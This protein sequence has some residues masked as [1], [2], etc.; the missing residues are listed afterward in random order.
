M[1]SVIPDIPDHV[2]AAM[3]A[4]ER[5]KL[6]RERR[7]LVV[8]ITVMQTRLE[9]LDQRLHEVAQGERVLSNH[10]RRGTGRY[11]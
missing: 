5:T 10:G 8:D 1:T 6:E 7:E 11:G 3:L 2:A 9:Q 4:R